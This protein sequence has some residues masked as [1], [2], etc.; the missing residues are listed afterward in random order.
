[1]T[2]LGIAQVCMCNAL[3]A[4][5]RI[6]EFKQ[7]YHKALRIH[8][9]ALS[10]LLSIDSPENIGS[11]YHHVG[12]CHAGLSEY[13]QAIDAYRNAVEWFFALQQRQFL[14]NSIA[15]IGNIAGL[16]ESGGDYCCWIDAEIAE[17]ALSDVRGDIV[18][19]LRRKPAR[20]LP[21]MELIRK[22][23]GVIKA[24]SFTSHASQLKVWADQFLEDDI[25]AAWSQFKSQGAQ[26]GRS[27]GWF[28]MCIEAELEIARLV[29][30][31][32]GN[33]RR[34]RTMVK[35]ISRICEDIWELSEVTSDILEP[36]AWIRHWERHLNRL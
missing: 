28:V 30:I 7:D 36:F 34:R 14:S 33:P 24:V 25:S 5:G 10:G 4:T 17:A 8:S 9:E 32:S 27:D 13:D 16:S 3:M 35:K 22:Q 29:A 2:N 26:R 21:E 23:F 11:A 1:M 12:N 15:E 6:Y 31:A 20:V 18:Q 19:W